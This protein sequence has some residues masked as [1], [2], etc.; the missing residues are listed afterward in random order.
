ML[1]FC[2]HDTPIITHNKLNVNKDIASISFHFLQGSKRLGFQLA[3]GPIRQVRMKSYLPGRKIQLL[4]KTRQHLF[5]PCPYLSQ[6]QVCVS[7]R[8]PLDTKNSSHL[9]E[10]LPRIH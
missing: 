6:C 3:I 5:E 8:H 7:S 4:D 2:I 10:G 9:F 1:A